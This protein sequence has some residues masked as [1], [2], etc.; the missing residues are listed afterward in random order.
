MF[1]H[2]FPTAIGSILG[3]GIRICVLIGIAWILYTA[4]NSFDDKPPAHTVLRENRIRPSDEDNAYLGT[5]TM[6][7]ALKEWPNETEHPEKLTPERAQELI[8]ANA[9]AL[10][11]FHETAARPVWFVAP[12]SDITL[13]TVPI[14]PLARIIRLQKLKIEA[15]IANGEIQAAVDG[16]KDLARFSTVMLSGTDGMIDFFTA[17]SFC[18]AAVTLAA[19]AAGSGKASD[20]ELKQLSETVQAV[21]PILTPAFERVCHRE[22]SGNFSSMLAMVD[23][24]IRNT[25]LRRWITRRYLLKPNRTKSLYLEHMR[26]AI[27]L[28]KNDFNREA[29][30][31]IEERQ[32]KTIR[33]TRNPFIPNAMGRFSLATLTPAYDRIVEKI[34]LV[35]THGAFVEITV[36]T[37][38][39]RRRT[40]NL[41]SEL[42]ALVPDYLPA[43]PIDPFNDGK[44]LKYDAE[45][46]TVY[47]VGAERTF[48]PSAKGYLRDRNAAHYAITLGEPGVR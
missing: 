36:A 45:H 13:N 12:R 34:T 2:P 43:V 46:R 40:G 7:Q 1:R 25:N 21:S 22:Y 5:L 33:L 32:A 15:S 14:K 48:N 18:G 9:E 47:T 20:D 24:D 44:P 29:W 30:K 39:M 8:E 4:L 23:Q 26:E 38:R 28:S 3:T 42:A 19:Q 10:A 27:A 6:T 37:E 11:L 16:I 35:K 41:P 17:L 31:T